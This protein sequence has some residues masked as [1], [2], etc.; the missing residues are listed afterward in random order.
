RELV[1]SQQSVGHA[2]LRKRLRRASEIRNFR[3][4]M[5]LS[6]EIWSL[7]ER[8][9]ARAVEAGLVAHPMDSRG[10]AAVIWAS[11]Q[12]AFVLM[13]DDDFF[14]ALTGLD[15][16]HFVEQAL[17][18][19]LTAAGS[20]GALSSHDGSNGR[21]ARAASEKTDTAAHPAPSQITDEEMRAGA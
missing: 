13:G 11:L 17:E 2:Q 5:Q 16:E 1:L 9:V 4:V 19:H 15:P 12:G 14:R 10:T 6:H 7:W 20:G 21:A 18:A 8:T 3:R